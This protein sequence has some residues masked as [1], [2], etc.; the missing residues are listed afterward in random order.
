MAGLFWHLALASLL[1]LSSCKIGTRN[2]ESNPAG[3]IDLL[4]DIKPFTKMRSASELHAFRTAFT[5]D[6]TFRPTLAAHKAP[7]IALQTI[8][9]RQIIAMEGI[10][11]AQIKAVLVNL[12][13]SKSTACAGVPCA[14]IF[15]LQSQDVDAFL[16]ESL[17]SI[18]NIAAIAEKASAKETLVASLLRNEAG[19]KTGWTIEM[20]P[21]PDSALWHHMTPY[22]SALY[23][24]FPVRVGESQGITWSSDFRA[25]VVWGKE[26]DE[27]FKAWKK[28]FDSVDDCATRGVKRGKVY[29]S[30]NDCLAEATLEEQQ[31]L[32]A[33]LVF[34]DVQAKLAKVDGKTNP[35]RQFRA[36][37]DKDG[38]MQCIVV[39]TKMPSMS[40][41]TSHYP[42]MVPKGASQIPAL[43]VNYLLAAPW[44]LK[45][46]HPKKVKGAGTACLGLAALESK[47]GPWGGRILLEGSPSAVPF[48]QKLGFT[49]VGEFFD[50][51]Y[52]LL[53]AMWLEPKYSEKL[54]PA[55]LH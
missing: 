20:V 29:S 4:A 35:R 21:E 27:Q 37:F 30:F 9:M 40:Y 34:D 54:V 28:E 18:E 32:S 48:Y 33:K 10:P 39:T 23:P 38:H 2:S 52:G 36:V 5:Q 44:N 3:I 6:Q 13:D 25:S 42:G 53:P 22:S 51:R 1:G 24:E 17:D 15:D 55:N 26:H 7:R 8:M 11:R 19:P 50:Q 16:D 43:E 31:Y 49:A 45:S 14:R 46:E 47:R 12:L 41:Y